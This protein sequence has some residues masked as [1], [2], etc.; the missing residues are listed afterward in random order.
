MTP[1]DSRTG[2]TRETGGSHAPPSSI[3]EW[4]RRLPP[5]PPPGSD[6]KDFLRWIAG[7]GWS[8]HYPGGPEPG[9]A[10]PDRSTLRRVA[11]EAFSGSLPAGSI[12][13]S[14]ET[15]AKIDETSEDRC[16][17]LISLLDNK[18]SANLDAAARQRRS[19]SGSH[20]RQS[21]HPLPTRPSEGGNR[22]AAGEAEAAAAPPVMAGIGSF[23]QQGEKRPGL[24]QVAMELRRLHSTGV[25]AGLLRK[26]GDGSYKAILQ[27]NGQGA[28]PDIIRLAAGL[29]EIWPEGLATL[30]ALARSENVVPMRRNGETAKAHASL[31]LLLRTDGVDMAPVAQVASRE[32]GFSAGGDTDPPPAGTSH[33]A[34]APRLADALGRMDE[35]DLEPIRHFD[36]MLDALGLDVPFPEESQDGRPFPAE[37]GN[38]GDR[39]RIDRSAVV[40]R[41][42]FLNREALMPIGQALRDV[43]CDLFDVIERR[44]GRHGMANE[45]LERLNDILL[46]SQWD[47][48]VPIEDHAA[49]ELPGDPIDGH[50][51]SP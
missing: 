28:D 7:M 24:G 39:N 22:G 45:A 26:T 44:H 38:L 23:F 8:R 29:H 2:V 32:T 48:W 20:S 16:R 12:A 50:G 15:L 51:F 31:L 43:A 13:V 25:L 11:L 40:K 42:L 19:A 9:M 41:V 4:T 36:N 49:R 37:I 14:A 10:Q 3:S 27:G 6:Q 34:D 30:T 35:A 47:S 33:K 5:A 17:S 46:S 1:P 18:L 21:S